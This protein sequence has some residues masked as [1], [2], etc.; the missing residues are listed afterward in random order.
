MLT[1]SVFMIWFLFGAVVIASILIGMN[2]RAFEET[3]VEWVQEEFKREDY[4]AR[5]MEEEKKERIEL[6]REAFERHQVWRNQ[7]AQRGLGD[8]GL[9]PKAWTQGEID[10]FQ[11]RLGAATMKLKAIA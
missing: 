2:M 7:R 9:F 6:L 10:L 8:V 11:S 3:Q 4:Q 1:S 5:V